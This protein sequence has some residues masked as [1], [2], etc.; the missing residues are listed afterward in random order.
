MQADCFTRQFSDG[1]RN[2]R[3]PARLQ[4]LN[5]AHGVEVGTVKT[6]LGAFPENVSVQ[7]NNGQFSNVKVDPAG[8]PGKTF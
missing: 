6:K 3:A 1:E 4:F 5:G 8:D 7:V 2:A